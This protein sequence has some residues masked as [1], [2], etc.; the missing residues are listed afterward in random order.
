MKTLTILRHAKSG[1]D[2]QVERDF[3]RP[4]NPR[5][6]RG[7]EH[8]RRTLKLGERTAG[9]DVRVT[10]RIDGDSRFV[11]KEIELR[12]EGRRFE[13]RV[14]LYGADELAALLTDA[15]L[16]IVARFGDYEGGAP[17]DDAP[18]VI[19]MARS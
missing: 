8:V 13:E 6:R 17:G 12:A 1:W 11:I 4:I 15:G 18:R 5:G 7:A 10:R 16:R 14:R 19:L 3:D 9:R 2:A